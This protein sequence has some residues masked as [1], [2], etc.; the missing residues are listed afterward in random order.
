V[1]KFSTLLVLTLLWAA[2]PAQGAW[3][4]AGNVVATSMVT[5]GVD[6]SLNSGGIARVEMLADDIVRIRVNP[7]GQISTRVSEALSFSSLVSPQV[8][9][10]DLPQA[11]YLQTP[12][13]TVAVLK[14]P[15]QVVILRADQ[16]LVT[17]DLPNGVQW[18]PIAGT[19]LVQR[20]AP[21][22][23]HYFG[24]GE[25]GGPLDRRGRTLDMV[26]VDWAGYSEFTDPLYINIPFFY[27]IREGQAY[28][29]F[30]NNVAEPFFQMD[31]T[32][33]GVLTYGAASGELDS[34]T[35]VGPQPQQVANAYARITG[36]PLLPPEWT[37]GYHQSRYGYSS[38]DQILQVAGALRELSIP[39]DAIY[40]D[41]DYMNAQ[42]AFTWNPATFP[43]PLQMNAE[44]TQLGF[45]Q[46]NIIEPL[47]AV[48]DQLWLAAASSGFLL[49]T[50]SGDPLITSLWYGYSGFIDFTKDTARTWFIDNLKT[51]LANGMSGTW[52]DLDEPASTFIPQATYNYN[53]DPRLDFQSRDAYALNFT[54]ASQ[55]AMRELRPNLRSWS[56]S[57]S[58]F[59]GIQRY[60]ANWSGD[61]NSTWDSL[62]VS[63]Q[64]TS[65]MALSGQNQFGHDIG[66]FLGSPS[67][68]LFVRWLEFAAYTPFF[69][70]HAMNTSAP[71]EP[72]VFG[73][74][75]TTIIRDT[76]NERYRMLPYLY[77]LFQHSST[78]A[79]PVVA[80][81][82]FYFPNDMATYNQDQEFM[83]GPSLLVAPVATEGAVSRSVYL[84]GGVNWIDLYTEQI[85]TGG[86]T[87]TASAPLEYIPVYVREGA[88][89]PFGPVMQY[90]GDP[91]VSPQLQ[92]NFYPGADAN[93]A[94]YEDDGATM[95]YNSGAYRTTQISRQQIAGETDLAISRAGGNWNPAGPRYFDVQ[96][97]DQYSAPSTVL[98]NGIAILPAA[99]EDSLSASDWGWFYS[100]TSNRLMIKLQ[101]ISP[102]LSVSIRQ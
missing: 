100:A 82:P 14:A 69:R 70:N 13:A 51:F 7:S 57:R 40:L 97:H 73:E 5:N 30:L 8:T 45:H 91:S 18:D 85:Y 41:I 10:F 9:V 29:I 35:F 81:L 61:T 67:A 63:V 66:G 86:Q 83:L 102:I 16:S 98:V 34:F 99:S 42:Q 93:F 68:E 64:L 72:W 37:L 44:L 6:F 59:S 88:I 75:Y 76:I 43:A 77:S 60:S 46:I 3:L 27:G 95:A 15:F 20:Y 17:A 96:V 78:S 25:R 47:I 89:L 56:L 28:G 23:E 52:N 79:D 19:V 39:C 22:D 32:S 87:I 92:L 38:Q 24:L 53:G 71:R 54:S 58:G 90:V 4:A 74:P 26:N 36:F 80:P 31:P 94:L 21:P 84:P 49:T 101:D 33:N 62:R 12:A 65:H 50:P 55:Q 1:P 48:T 2:T 11:T